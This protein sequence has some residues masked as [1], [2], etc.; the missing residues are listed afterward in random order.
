VTN[1][2]AV[3]VRLGKS[4]A[5]VG[6]I[7]GVFSGLFAGTGAAFFGSSS[8]GAIGNNLSEAIGSGAGACDIGLEVASGIGFPESV[9]GMR[10]GRSLSVTGLLGLS[11]GGNVCPDASDIPTCRANTASKYWRTAAPL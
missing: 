6:G 3:F 1:G 7:L 5:E 2:E 11:S 8:G 4:L 10:T 9:G